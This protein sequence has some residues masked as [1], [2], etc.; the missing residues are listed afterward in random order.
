[1]KRIALKLLASLCRISVILLLI[2]W[3]AITP[4]ENWNLYYPTSTEYT[5]NPML[6]LKDT[7]IPHLQEVF[8][9]TD[10]GVRLNGWFVP[11]VDKTKPT[12]L[13]A[14]GN[15]GNL[16]DCVGV[17]RMFLKRGYGFFAFD[18]RGYGKSQG[19]PSEKGLYQDIN[20]ASR[21]LA[22]AQRIPAQRQIAVGNSLGT[23]VVLDAATHLP[24]RAVVVSSS[25]TSAPAVADALR[26]SGTMQWLK[27][28]PLQHLMG[29]TYDSLSKMPKIHVPLLVLH[30]DHDHMMP[31]SMSKALYKQAGSAH[32]VLLIIPNA[33]HNS[34]LFQGETQM[35]AQ[36]DRL[37][38]ESIHAT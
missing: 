32:K 29:Q 14:H 7:P 5:G 35:F 21:Y 2:G 15:A 16:G 12:I 26:D 34:A 11:P 22:Q 1:M 20:A 13:F 33:G 18:Y 24:F 6:A 30:G 38:A 9:R 25:L 17:M 10:D 8:F 28:L 31:V 36:L 37:L 19:Q 23:A 4:L 27:F 3:A